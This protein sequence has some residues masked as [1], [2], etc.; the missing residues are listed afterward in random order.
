M[1]I[2]YYGILQVA[3]NSTDLEI[4]KAYDLKYYFQNTPNIN[5]SV[6]EVWL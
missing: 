4:K 1:G 2:D 6:T 5:I 3:R